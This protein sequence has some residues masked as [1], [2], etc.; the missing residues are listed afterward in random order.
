VG[1]SCTVVDAMTLSIR[2]ASCEDTATVVQ[3]LQEA[4]RWL[5]ER[6][7]TLWR[8]AELQPE[9]IASEV[10]QGL[11]FLAEDSGAAKG[12]IRFQL[13]DP[14]FWPDMPT[15]E[16]AFVH[17][18]AVRRSAAGGSVSQTLLRWA[19]DRTRTLGLRYLRLDTEASRM[20]LRGLYEEFGF[21]HHSDRQVGPYYVARYEY[22]V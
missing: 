9:R 3:I 7:Q 12:T 4:A 16:A 8:D 21:R 22:Q 20:R 19:V 10:Q 17:R 15:G 1:R 13:Q 11:Y 5:E 6:G 18:L 14:E 2:Q